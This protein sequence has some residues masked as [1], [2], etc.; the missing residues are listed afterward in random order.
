VKYKLETIP[1]WDAVRSGDGCP[2]CALMAEAQRRYIDYYLG[3]S[4][5]N[6]ET[7]VAVNTT[8]FCPEHYR[9]LVLEPKPQA[10]ALITDTHLQ[11]TERQ[12]RDTLM[13]LQS[14]QN[15]RKGRKVRD[16]LIRLLAERESGCLICERMERALARYAYTL[17]HMWANDPEFREEYAP[18]G[19]CLFHLPRLLTIAE[20]ALSADRRAELE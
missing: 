1:V 14:V 15:V 8:G 6:P 13:Q 11:E 12:L 10:L 3:S 5:M 18:G 17:V 19:P 4:V 16:E 7:R 2:L 9:L 20:E